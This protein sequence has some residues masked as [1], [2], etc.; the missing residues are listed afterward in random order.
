M[1]LNRHPQHTFRYYL[2]KRITLLN[3]YLIYITIILNQ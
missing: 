2:H 3:R 1:G